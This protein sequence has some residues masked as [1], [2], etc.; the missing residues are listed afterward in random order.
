[1]NTEKNSVC[2]GGGKGR[3]GGEESEYAYNPNSPDTEARE[4]QTLC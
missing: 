4:P 3:G 1:M 2:V